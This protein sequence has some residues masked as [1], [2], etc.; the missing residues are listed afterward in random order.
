MVES[1]GVGMDTIDKIIAISTL[2][3]GLKQEITKFD[4]SDLVV[5]IL[6]RIEKKIK[7]PLAD[8]ER[9]KIIDEFYDKFYFYMDIY[10]V[11]AVDT[12]VDFLNGK[13]NYLC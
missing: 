1:I 6:Y 9:N 8:I 2:R 11:S 3:A 13:E 5:D 7:R 10:P 4:K 12:L